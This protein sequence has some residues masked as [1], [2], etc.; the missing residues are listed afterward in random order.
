MVYLALRDE[1]SIVN[2]R[3]SVGV[4]FSSSH[5]PSTNTSSEATSMMPHLRIVFSVVM[6]FVV[7]VDTKFW[8]PGVLR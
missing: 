5:E 8:H 2:C 6:V 3:V 7:F 1:D 4:N